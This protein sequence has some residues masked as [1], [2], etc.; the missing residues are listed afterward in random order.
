MIIQYYVIA[1]GVYM[2]TVQRSPHQTTDT[3]T[4]CIFRYHVSKLSNN[5]CIIPE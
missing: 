1:N 4:E 3:Q 2:Y 5:F